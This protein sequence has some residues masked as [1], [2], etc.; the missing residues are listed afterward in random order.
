M[1][2]L[3]SEEA[4][5]FKAK[6]IALTSALKIEQADGSRRESTRCP[7]TAADATLLPSFEASVYIV[8]YSDA[9]DLISAKCCRI[10]KGFVSDFLYCVSLKLK[11]GFGFNHGGFSGITIGAMSS[12][13][14]SEFSKCDLT[15]RPKG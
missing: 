14:I 2:I 12:K 11:V 8:E 10:S 9:T 1:N 5:N 4:T 7:K 15:R 13:L 6:S 3:F